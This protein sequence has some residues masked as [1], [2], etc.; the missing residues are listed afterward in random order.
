M[1]EL[2]GHIS[3]D[4]LSPE[5]FV[6]TTFSSHNTLVHFVSKIVLTYCEKKKILVKKK[7]YLITKFVNKTF[8][9]SHFIHV[10]VFNPTKKNPNIFSPSRFVKGSAFWCWKTVI[11]FVSFKDLWLQ[12]DYHLVGSFKSFITVKISGQKVW[13]ILSW[14][15]FFASDCCYT[16]KCSKEKAG[17]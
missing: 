7:N 16:I 5:I 9:G 1:W 12:M 17:F 4:A 15:L 11:S 10:Y 6:T 3:W 2:K 13:K 8:L 14:K